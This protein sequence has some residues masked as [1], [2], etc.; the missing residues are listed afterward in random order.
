[1]PSLLG[2]DN[3]L[4]VTK[5]V[6]FDA[7]GTQLAVARRRVPQSIPQARHVE[8]DMNGLWRATAEAIAE[9]IEGSGRLAGD[10]AAVARRAG[11]NA[12]SHPPPHRPARRACRASSTCSAR[13][14]SAPISPAR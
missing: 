9:A 14:R 3:G 8:R 7:D 4:T 10:I 5:A 1:M 12:W 11:L 2:I 6:I 13:C